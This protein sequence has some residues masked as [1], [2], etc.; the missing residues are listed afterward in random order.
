MLSITI[1]PEFTRRLGLCQLGPLVCRISSDRLRKSSFW[2]TDKMEPCPKCD[3]FSQRFNIL[4]PHEYQDIVRQLNEVVNQG[5]L[6]L[7]HASCPLQ[8]M[9][10]ATSP[11]DTIFH[12]F[13][14]FA[15]G[16]TFQLFADTYHGGA[17]WTIGDLQGPVGDL[18]KPN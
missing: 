1:S 15:C 14:C 9:L 17:S 3:G 7:V 8:D 10:N 5:T 2:Q 16:R 18:P 13:Q 12:N 4:D 6:L 11:G